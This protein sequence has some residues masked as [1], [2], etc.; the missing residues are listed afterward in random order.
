MI[1]LKPCPFCG[2]QAKF[3]TKVN[4][5]KKYR[6]RLVLWNILHGMRRYNAED[7]LL[8]GGEPCRLRR[9]RDTTG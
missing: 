3:F 2:G 7:K 6:H 4:D 1:E 8:H 9:N 5:A